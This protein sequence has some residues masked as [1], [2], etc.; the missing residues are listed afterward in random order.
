M[1]VYFPYLNALGFIT[2]FNLTL[3][4]GLA[5]RGNTTTRYVDFS[6]GLP[7]AYTGPNSS[8]QQ[9]ATL[10]FYNA[11]ISNNYTSL[12][13]PGFWNLPPGPEIPED[14]LLPI[15]AFAQKYN[16]TAA[17][18]RIWSAVGGGVGSRGNFTSQL[19][20]TVLQSFSPAWIKVYLGSPIYHIQDG[21]QR[22]YNAIAAMLGNDVLLTSTVTASSRNATGVELLVSTPSGMKLIIA[23]KLLLAIPPT[24]ETLIP[25]DLNAN[26][27]QHFSRP[28]YGRYH[29]ALISHPSLPRGVELTN[30]PP[31]SNVTEEPVLETPYILSLS[32]YGNDSSLSGLGTSGN[33]YASYTP[34]AGAALAERN[35]QAMA[36]AGTVH[37]LGGKSMEIVE[38]S[39]HQAGGYGVSAQEMRGGWMERMYSLQGVRSTWFTGNAIAVDFST[40]L[41]GFNDDLLER[42]FKAW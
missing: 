28:Q 11:L 1:Q 16:A 34:G 30:V 2:R 6:T 10:N 22:L 13:E 24:R 18:S 23:K 7:S 26:E 9:A 33:P 5:P 3:V 37:D 36:D 19:T 4:P 40:V 21:N 35:L 27:T 20:L 14:L 29:T 8:L 32:S 38:W 17:L 31:S 12:I 15:G 39:D 41:W 25:F 42:M